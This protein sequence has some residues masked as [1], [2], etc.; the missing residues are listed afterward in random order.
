MGLVYST[1]CEH[2]RLVIVFLGG[3]KG[4][5]AKKRSRHSD[6]IRIMYGDTGCCTISEEVR[7]DS[8]TKSRLGVRLKLMAD[9][10]VG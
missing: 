6:L 9:R 7:G 8:N 3:L 1:G 2:L 4:V 5:M 10:F